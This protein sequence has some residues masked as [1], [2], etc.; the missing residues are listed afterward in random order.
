MHAS[1]PTPRIRTARPIPG[2]H[3]RSCIHEV[4]ATGL[5]LLLLP[6]MPRSMCTPFAR[7]HRR[8]RR[9]NRC[10]PNGG[11]GRGQRCNFVPPLGDKI[12]SSGQRVCGA[13]LRMQA[14]K[15]G[16]PG[17]CWAGRSSEALFRQCNAS[18]ARLGPPAPCGSVIG[19]EGRTHR[20]GVAQHYYSIVGLPH[21]SLPMYTTRTHTHIPEEVPARFLIADR[22]STRAPKR[23]V[24]VKHFIHCIQN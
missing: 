15:S 21:Q 20:P 17:A 5:L 23:I 19:R 8:S 13:K 6:T 3:C 24:T 10:L 1:R 12:A 9:A 11:S 22:R 2:A 16:L 4:S 7:I 18:C 14:W